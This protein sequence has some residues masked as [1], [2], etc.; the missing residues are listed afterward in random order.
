MTTVFSHRLKKGENVKV[1]LE[2][3][4]LSGSNSA[5]RSGWNG[6]CCPRQRQAA[7]GTLICSQPDKKHRVESLNNA[8]VLEYQNR[9][10]PG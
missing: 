9:S 4:R 7:E 6:L 10:Q 2:R 8:V 5:A 3:R 1:E